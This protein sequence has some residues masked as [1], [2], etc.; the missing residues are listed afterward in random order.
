M[1]T[2][3]RRSGWELVGWL[4]VAFF[5]IVGTFIKLTSTPT[6]PPPAPPQVAP[7]DAPDWD[8]GPA[9]TTAWGDRRVEARAKRPPCFACRCGCPA[10][11]HSGPGNHWRPRVAFLMDHRR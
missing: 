5:V 10:K 3:P 1:Q 9:T 4:W 8:P 7:Q 2:A 6:P 11:P